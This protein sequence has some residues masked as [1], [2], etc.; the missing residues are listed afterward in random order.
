MT[1]ANMLPMTDWSDL[2]F[3]IVGR[4][5][6]LENMPDE[7]YRFVTQNYFRTLRI[8]VK[9]GREFTERDT[10]DSE[11]V[12]VINEAFAREYFP[13][14]NPLG[15]Q[16]LVARIMGTCLPTSQGGL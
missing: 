12:M 13:K 8:P 11:R 9:R 10:A 2:P 7:K 1:L 6:K 4:P 14:Q 5:V 16:I 15:E 3:E